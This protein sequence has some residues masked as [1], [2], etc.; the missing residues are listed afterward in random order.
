M[1]DRILNPE[2]HILVIPDTS[3][4]KPTP[5]KTGKSK[6]LTNNLGNETRK[7]M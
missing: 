6:Q 5:Q 7:I 3:T 1:R 2:H 4:I